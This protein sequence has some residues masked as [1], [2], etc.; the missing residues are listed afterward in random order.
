[1]TLDPK[2]QKPYTLETSNLYNIAVSRRYAEVKPQ[3]DGKGGW[4][5]KMTSE[6]MRGLQDIIY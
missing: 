5:K 3:R 6:D 2:P 4:G 1:L